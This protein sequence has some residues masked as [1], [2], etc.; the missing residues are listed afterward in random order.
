MKNFNLIERLWKTDSHEKQTPQRFG[1]YAV[2]L[3]LLLTLG[4]GQMWGYTATFRCVPA[5]TFGSNWSSSNTCKVKFNADNGWGDADSELSPTGL[6]YESGGNLYEIYSVTRSDLP[7][8]GVRNLHFERWDGS[9]WKENQGQYND[10]RN[11]SS[12]SGSMH[13]GSWGSY[14]YKTWDIPANTTIVWDAGKESWT[15]AQLYIFKD[16]YNTADDFTRVGST[17][18]FTKK[19]TTK[20][21]GYAGLIIRKNSDWNAQTTNIYTDVTSSTTGVTLFTYQGNKS[22]DKLNWQKTTNAKKATS[23]VKIYFDNTDAKWGEVWLKYGTQWYNRSSAA[24]ATK[25]TGT[26]NLYVITIPN[27]AYYEKYYLANHYGYTGYNSIETMTN[28]SNRIN[29]Q[30]SN[31]ASDITYIPSTGSGSNPKV[32][33]TTTLSGHT[34]TLT[35]TAPSNG[36]ISATYTDENGP[37]QTVTSGSFTVA[38][39]CKVT[40]TATPNTGYAL[41]GL[42]LGGASITSGAEQII[43]ADGTIAATFVAETTHD[44]TVS[45]KIGTRTL[46]ADRVVA[47]GE[48]TPSNIS[49]ETVDG[50]SFSSWSNLTSG[51]TNVTGNTTTDPIRIKTTADA[52]M[53]C[54][55]TQW[56]CSLDIVPSEGATTYTSRTP[57]SYD[58]TTKAYYKNVS[59]ASATERYRFYIDYFITI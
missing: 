3:I 47:V 12:W 5:L 24:A 16:G 2:I 43:R 6:M 23:G 57:M 25:V 8:D 39:T 53:T 33:N 1:R 32:W 22:C 34:R 52:S 36:S 54:N 9:T 59:T 20:W 31:I 7:G 13:Y 37:E 48:T 30:A 55:Y 29:Y 46:H 35:I 4:V 49:S 40:I 14:S 26:D 58:A 38:Q 51:I 18:Q 27:D 11:C 28:I 19:Y 50:F 15:T 56:P 44:V 10:W 21:A 17:T 45:Y 41:S 42:T